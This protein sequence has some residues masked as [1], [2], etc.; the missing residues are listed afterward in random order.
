M[1]AEIDEVF[2]M[3]LFGVYR[4]PSTASRYTPVPGA[5]A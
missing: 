5:L 1:L 3:S 2:S 4:R